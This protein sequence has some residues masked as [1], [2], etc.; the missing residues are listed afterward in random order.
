MVFGPYDPSWYVNGKIDNTIKTVAKRIGLSFYI[1]SNII[2]E[3]T[4]ELQENKHLTDIIMES[5]MNVI[6]E[7][8][9]KLID[10]IKRAQTIVK[11]NQPDSD[12]GTCNVDSV[13]IKLH[14]W[15]Q[16]DVDIVN[17]RTG[18]RISE[19]LSGF[20]KGYR[21]IDVGAKGQAEMRTKMCEIGK[22]VL[23]DCDQTVAIYYQMD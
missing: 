19:P 4:K 20:W 9:Q 10:D 2:T 6:S 5:K 13:V 15:K 14:R 17:L 3:Y 1:V 21:F 12:G 11:N 22:K 8:V 16:S 18:A 23:Q 7:K